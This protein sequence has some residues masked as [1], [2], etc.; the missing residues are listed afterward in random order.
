MEKPF[1]VYTSS[2]GSGKTYTLTKEYLKLALKSDDP[3][4]F[5]HILAI[6]FTND[7]ANEMKERILGAL[8]GFADPDSLP[9][10]KRPGNQQ[11]LDIIVQEL[12]QIDRVEPLTEQILR[13][14][15]G[16]AFSHILHDYSDFAVSTIDS[17]VNRLV[18][19]FTE[20]LDI[21][22]N[23]EVSM[24]G[25]E[26]VSNAVDRLLNRIGHDEEKILSEMLEAYALEI[27]DEGKSWNGLP[28]NL[29]EFGAQLL[30]EKVTEAMDRIKHLTMDDF[31]T[32]RAII[33]QR[34]EE[35]KTKIAESAQMSLETMQTYGLD[36]KYFQQGQ[37]GIWGYFDKNANNID[38]EL[39]K[40]VSPT[41][42]ELFYADEWASKTTK[43]EKRRAIAEL[44]PTLFSV[45]ENIEKMKGDWLLLENILQHYY[46]LSVIHEISHELR[47]IKS[48]K[49]QVLI[50]D[51]NQALV[52]IILKEPV[53]FIYERLGE[54]YNHILIDEFQDTS[55]LQWNNLLP[56]L[57]NGLAKGHF[58]LIVGDAKQAI[59]RW[60]GGDMEQIVHLSNKR[61]DVLLSRH[62]E[63][64]LLGV[65][66][67]TINYTLAK[68]R[69]NTN[70]RSTREIIE[71]NNDIFRT[72][73]DMYGADRQLLA[74]VYDEFAS[75]EVPATAK[76][77]GHIEI[78]FIDSAKEDDDTAEDGLSAYE[79]RT[80]EAVLRNVQDVLEAGYTHRD[81]AVLCRQNKYAR[82]VA[83][84]LKD[85]GVDIISQDSLLLQSSPAISL[86][87]SFLKILHSPDDTL[88]R[89]EALHLFYQHILQQMP[90]LTPNEW[91]VMRKGSS[92]KPLFS[93]L[94][95]KEYF[96]NPFRLQQM[97]LY[98]LGATLV[99]TFRLAELNGQT[100]Y[101][102]RFL[103]VLLDFS[104]KQSNHLGEFMDFWER[105]KEVLYINTPKDKD[106]VTVTSVHKSKGLEYPI[107]LVPFADW[108]M[109][110]RP[111]EIWW[112]SLDTNRL[113]YE[114]PYLKDISLRSTPITP[115]KELTRTPLRKQ[116]EEDTE[117]LFIEN[118][119]LLYV[120]LT[121][122][123]D[124]LYLLGKEF[125]FSKRT[126][127][128]NV[129]M[130]LHDYLDQKELWE[131]HRPHYILREGTL[132][133][134][135]KEVAQENEVFLVTN[136]PVA[137]WHKKAR[138]RRMASRMF[139]TETFEKERDH[140]QKLCEALRHL[141]SDAQIELCLD[142]FESEGSIS[143][144]ERN[145]F[146]RDLEEIIS[147]SALRP[148]FSPKAEVKPVKD[149]LSRHTLNLIPPDRVIV[150]GSA[151]TIMSY[152]S[153]DSQEDAEKLL[154]RYAKALRQMGYQEVEKL[155]VNT[156]TL[157]VT[158]FTTAVGS[159]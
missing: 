101:I 105:K 10:N 39:D 151:V 98:E 33:E 56:L 115:K 25:I 87:I 119:N 23:Y 111:G 20:E 30:S 147:Q 53:P 80:L 109:F 132:K 113:S 78:Q 62:Q 37:R 35:L 9:E 67:E 92:L 79:R 4:Y 51:F 38:R 138:L 72:L 41:L 55:V 14:R 31:K 127:R 83:N 42:Q 70:F 136:D 155:I 116:Y 16:R 52:N 69:L 99:Q 64:D 86:L 74:E 126:D 75:Q 120:A 142:K 148:H 7:A 21:P 124:R 95:G 58:S 153:G 57:E 59:Y 73:A 50:S 100:P 82:L 108:D 81:I 106:A 117:K 107:V 18:G 159:M 144:S 134:T 71:F 48:D 84:F 76:T 96:L 97:G 15:A 66:Y 137:D 28:D 90:Q 135:P 112:M 45:F 65:R 88:A 68:E 102:Y 89:Y 156:Q 125:D 60:R 2:A 110:P 123:T 146:R 24:E 141:E 130:L 150:N 32:T 8:R 12:N 131:P 46:K 11:L 40:E 17:F 34:K 13:R 140:A 3:F 6:T 94:E 44:Q 103:D 154:N 149:I 104:V 85:R 157:E 22:F 77:G 27:T 129:S 114:S 36:S 19:A 49:N 54:K 139:D 118:M 128:I 145:S 47:L 152:I 91:E 143:E 122:P 158:T 121:R 26:L 29:A 133:P 61:F 63:P 5:R 1:K 93:H 43:E